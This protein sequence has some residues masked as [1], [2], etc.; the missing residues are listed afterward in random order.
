MNLRR[1]TKDE[2]R[3]NRGGCIRDDVTE[4]TKTGELKELVCSGDDFVFN[5]FLNFKPV[6][7]LKR[8]KRYDHG[9]VSRNNEC[10]GGKSAGFW[11][12]NSI[13]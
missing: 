2:D 3:V 7:R 13:Q 5:T 8:L 9:S 1:M 4:I 6:K 10:A 12:G 11:E